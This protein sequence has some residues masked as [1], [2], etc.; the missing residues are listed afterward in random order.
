LRR[1]R[2]VGV[3]PSAAHQPSRRRPSD[4][5]RVFVFRRSNAIRRGRVFGVLKG[6]HI[7][8][9][10][11]RDHD[12]LP[13]RVGV[14]LAQLVAEPTGINPNDRIEAGIELGVTA[15]QLERQDLFFETVRLTGKGPL[16]DVAQECCKTRGSLE[17]RAVENAFELRAHGGVGWPPIV[18][19]P[20]VN[21]CR[22]PD[23]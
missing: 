18:C 12:R 23:G 16:D 4:W 21:R 15:V 1:R 17:E 6:R 19:Q 9:L 11:Q 8:A 7:A 20:N 13:W 3:T 10:R 5:A 14:V 2:A 22:P